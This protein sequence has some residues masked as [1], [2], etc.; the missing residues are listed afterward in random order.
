MKKNKTIK[1]RVCDVCGE[2]T[3][4]KCVCG[5]DIC[6][7]CGFIIKKLTTWSG[8]NYILFATTASEEIG[9]ICRSH[10]DCKILKEVVK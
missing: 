1:V 3:N 9:I 7:N 5:K 10:I 2:E 8:E 6:G 4:A